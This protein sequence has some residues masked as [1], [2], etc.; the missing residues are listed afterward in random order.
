MWA[1]GAHY[2]CDNEADGPSHVTFDSRI[3]HITDGTLASKIDVRVLK[4]I[5][6]VNFGSMSCVVMEGS[7]IA[8]DTK[9]GLMLVKTSTVF[10]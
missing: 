2:Q 7:W 3:A 6:L 8:G 4:S 1:Y 5:F 10:G 9:R